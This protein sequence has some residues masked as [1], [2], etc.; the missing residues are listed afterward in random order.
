MVH[1]NDE[2]LDVLVQSFIKMK[3]ELLAIADCIEHKD[4]LKN[5]QFS[6]NPNTDSNQ[7]HSQ[8]IFL[9]LVENVDGYLCHIDKAEAQLLLFEKKKT[10]SLPWNAVLTIGSK[11]HISAYV[12][13]QKEAILSSFKT[14]CVDSNTATKLV[15]EYTKNNQPIDKPEVEGEFNY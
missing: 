1:T 7:S 8:T 11:L 14:E 5:S 13:V 3:V 9:N 4:S 2:N 10:R 6:Q 12:S 15:T